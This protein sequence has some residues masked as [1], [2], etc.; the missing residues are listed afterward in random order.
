MSSS[1][2]PSATDELAEALANLS[3]ECEQAITSFETYYLDLAG[4]AM[5]LASS[6]DIDEE[7][8]KG[9]AA[10]ADELDR[11]ATGLDGVLP[12]AP[13]AYADLVTI[14]RG[15]ATTLR[16]WSESHNSTDGLAEAMDTF[17]EG[18]VGQLAFVGVIDDLQ[19]RC[20]PYEWSN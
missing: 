3:P 6:G 9:L 13:G 14:I 1:A 19:V 12:D 15:Q 4:I 20:A 16:T 10:A 5:S 18:S 17:T 2:S 8:K 7:T 11:N